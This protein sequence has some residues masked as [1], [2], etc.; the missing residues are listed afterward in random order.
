MGEELEMA[1]RL[2]SPD[3]ARRLDDPRTGLVAQVAAVDWHS[4]GATFRFPHT[5]AVADDLLDFT[6]IERQ[7]CPFLDFSLALPGSA[8]E[9]RLTLTSTV[10][11]GATFICQTFG[12]LTRFPGDFSG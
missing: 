6:R 4:E 3:L 2:T 10:T 12:P 11:G 9:A 1:C 7:C 8:P 5:D